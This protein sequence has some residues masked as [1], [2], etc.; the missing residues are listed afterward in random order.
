MN[1]NYM[2]PK[3]CKGEYLQ[4][5]GDIDNWHLCFSASLNVIQ[6]E[7]TH[8]KQEGESNVGN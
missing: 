8:Y 2:A 7:N 6:S 5:L 4:N 1:R 3:F